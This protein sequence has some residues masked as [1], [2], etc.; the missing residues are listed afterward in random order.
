MRTALLLLDQA[1]AA[2]AELMTQLEEV[3]RDTYRI[4][5]SCPVCDWTDVVVRENRDAALLE[6]NDRIAK[7][8]IAMGHQLSGAPRPG[9]YRGEPVN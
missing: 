2:W 3:M 6:G 5:L 9:Y 8:N 4:K 1:Q 7:H